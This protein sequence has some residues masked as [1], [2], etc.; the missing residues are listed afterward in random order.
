[1]KALFLSIC[2]FL[3]TTLALG[4]ISPE[5]V[6]TAKKHNVWCVA[7]SDDGRYIASG[8]DDGSIVIYTTDTYAEISRFG[9]LKDVPV[10]VCFSHDGKKIAAAGKDMK[11]T[12]W[13]FA[14]KTLLFE[15]KGHKGFIIKIEFSPN[16]KIIASASYDNTVKL[17][18]ANTGTL[19]STLEGHIK[20]VN[21][22]SFSPNGEQIV[23]GSA[24]KTIKIW[25]VSSA[26]LFL[27]IPAHTNW[28]RG[29]AYSPD[30]SIIAS[31]GDDRQIHLWDAVS[32]KLINT[33]LGHKN[34]ISA[35]GFSPD[36]N[37]LLSGDQ[38]NILIL[39]D[40]RSGKMVFQSTKQSNKI[41]A[42][43]FNPTGK[44][45]AFAALLDPNLQVWD[46]SKL[47]IK[48]LSEKGAMQASSQSGMVP[49]VEWISP[50]S[51]ITSNEASL[52]VK[53]NINSESSLR[54]I[55]L[56][57][58]NTLF[59]SKDR[60]ELM[61]ET[62]DNNITKY[63]ELVILNEGENTIQIKAVN[64]V[65]E[66]SSSKLTVNYS[67][68]PVE[69]LA[70]I[71]PEVPEKETNNQ[72]FEAIA[73]INKAG[74]PQQ[75]TVLVN[76]K[77][78]GTHA[79]ESIG[80][81]VKQIINLVPGKNAI[82]FSIKTSLYTKESETRVVNFIPAL[83]PDIVWVNPLA[84]A[85]SF[86]SSVNL[87]ANINSKI[88]IDKI[89]VKVNGVAVFTQSLKDENTFVLE[90]N[91]QV[92]SGKNTILIVASNKTGETI[93]QPKVITYQAPEKTFI[94]WISPVT[95]TN[96]YIPSI[97]LK[98]CI[99]SKSDVSAIKIFNNEVLIHSAENPTINKTGECAI[100]LS[101]IV[102]LN[103]GLNSF[104]IEAENVAGVTYSELMKATYVI[105]QLA[106]TKWVE[107]AVLQTS[108][109]EKNFK[110][111]ACINSNT[112]I[113]TIDLIANSQII[114]LQPSQQ[115]AQGECTFV[116][117]Q[118]ISLN[119]GN[120]TVMLKVKNVAG[121][122]ISQPLF[123]DQKSANPYRFALIIGNEDYS[124]Y[125]TGINSE[126]NVD[127][128]LNDAREFKQMCITQLGIKDEKIVYLENARQM[129]MVRAVNKLSL[130][131]KASEGKA[132]VYVYYAGHGF[133]D[134][135]TK[136]PF[137][138]PVDVSGTDLAFGGGIK[139]AQFYELLTE[140]PAQRI[141]VF[142]DA[143]FS[144]GARN[145]GLVAAR[146]VKIV[147]KETKEAVK[148][149]L[150][151]YAASSGSETSLPYKEKKHG[152]FTY[153]LL[154]KINETNGTVNYKDLSDYLKYEVNVNSLLI[155][156]KEQQPQ[157]N[158]SEQVGEEWK[159]WTFNE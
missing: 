129:E 132:E 6:L 26:S 117:E 89:A 22:L 81:L 79:V 78:A 58:N 156:N 70:W 85:T 84:D 108:T 153:Y 64:I 93:S 9:G 55:E 7:Y 10:S 135:K 142:L 3:I 65:G 33:F 138:I 114:S 148:K 24:D 20:E 151:V 113:S 118:L 30:G 133:P 12:V 5:K 11:V 18:D 45:F 14:S 36:G 51:N 57:V 77:P 109:T 91:I 39:T 54:K 52:M 136:E 158:V 157:T 127:F 86:I 23:S 49:K 1:M 21:S 147:P 152:M 17:W 76:G 141:T 25:N 61:M 56:Y 71:Q 34:W 97:E 29:V 120:N 62:A 107:P 72:Q 53:A 144:G 98:A 123:I 125:Q 47:N 68:I 105:P 95:N 101:K 32:G 83:K 154:K 104:K 134:E 15:S 112:P 121:E 155:N 42:I 75:V 4:Q 27:N 38:D 8:G 143:C 110:L 73:T 66:T 150:I 115:A 13:D 103:Q 149:N 131:I 159:T 2:Y 99:Q 69:L 128:A 100:E 90:K 122:V 16:D 137:L 87:K 31:G 139:V 88:P 28:V 74:V 96:V 124:S 67:N 130:L 35:L 94:S 140:H 59:N 19:K 46:A 80:G 82:V 37:Y 63:E 111:K 48:P 43:A 119:S 50:V 102:V 126:S 145:Q 92:A 40:I 106:T 146:G 41:M 116:F 44:N 60:A